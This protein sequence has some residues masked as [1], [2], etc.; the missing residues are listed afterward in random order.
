MNAKQT[1]TQYNVTITDTEFEVT[2]RGR[3]TR[4]PLNWS[5][6]MGAFS[7][8][9]SIDMVKELAARQLLPVVF[10]D[11]AGNRTNHGIQ[12]TAAAFEQAAYSGHVG[13]GISMTDGY[14]APESFEAW[15][16]FFRQDPQHGIKFSNDYRPAPAVLEAYLATLAG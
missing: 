9:Y 12:F 3:T 10:I 2:V 4:H 14:Y 15:V 7:C 8:G 5:Q 6:G 1:F 13:Y 11:E 16:H